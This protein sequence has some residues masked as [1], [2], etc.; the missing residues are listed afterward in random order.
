MKRIAFQ[1]VRKPSRFVGNGIY[2]GH[3]GSPRD[4]RSRRHGGRAKACASAAH[5]IV[6]N[7][8]YSR[9][10]RANSLIQRV[11]FDHRDAG[12]VVHAADDRGVGR[13]AGE[14]FDQGGLAIVR[15]RDA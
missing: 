7:S 1:V 4:R 11:N 8:L 5:V 13:V 9:R 2:S 14:R 3:F 6:R 10:G 15:R 12:G